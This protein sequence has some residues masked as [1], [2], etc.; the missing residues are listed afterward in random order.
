M[1]NI[2]SLIIGFLLATCMFL[3]MGNTSSNSGQGKYQGFA[4]DTHRYMIDTYTGETWY[5]SY[6]KENRKEV[7]FWKKLIAPYDFRDE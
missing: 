6:N 5:K 3:F 4:N 2:K 1:K 7:H